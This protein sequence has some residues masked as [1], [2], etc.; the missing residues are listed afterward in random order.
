MACC[1][2]SPAWFRLCPPTARRYFEH[3][4]K[5]T[6]KR[7]GLPAGAPGSFQRDRRSSSV[8]PGGQ[9][10]REMR[11]AEWTASLRDGLGCCP[12]AKQKRGSLDKNVRRA[13][14]GG[15]TRKPLRSCP[16]HGSRNWNDRFCVDRSLAGASNCSKRGVR[17]DGNCSAAALER[18]RIW[19]C[20]SE[21]AR[22]HEQR[23]R[24]MES[25]EQDQASFLSKLKEEKQV[26]LAARTEWTDYVA[27]LEDQRRKLMSKR[28]AG[29]GSDGQ[30]C[31]LDARANC[32][33][34]EGRPWKEVGSLQPDGTCWPAPPMVAQY[35]VQQSRPHELRNDD[36]PAEESDDDVHSVAPG[37]RSAMD[38]LR[39][40][41]RSGRSWPANVSAATHGMNTAGARL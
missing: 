18:R 16:C 26:F 4:A 30:A 23:S 28:R 19:E 27:L 15:H 20:D 9:R 32:P 3:F 1:A 33:S 35:A 24:V 12:I 6:D 31:H 10:K 38:R 29:K 17:I 2:S 25:A 37:R 41:L 14:G 8:P 11:D 22:L 21:A 5:A 36:S 39:D 13:R 7:L 34:C 40:V